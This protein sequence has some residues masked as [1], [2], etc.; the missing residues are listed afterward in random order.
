M[1]ANT[2]RHPKSPSCSIQSLESRRLMAVDL[3]VTSI[4]MIDG[5]HDNTSDPT[6]AAITVTNFGDQ[7]ILPGAIDLRLRFSTDDVF[8][9]E[10]DWNL[11]FVN[12]PSALGG[13]ESWTYTM[14]RRAAGQG[15]GSFRLI[16]FADGFDLITETNETNNIMVTD[17]GTVVYSNG[18]LESTDIYGTSFNDVITL[19]ADDENAYVTVN[20]N[21]HHK[22]I[23]DIAKHIFIDG[24]AGND[25]ITASPD[26]PV[27]LAIT[28]SGGKDLIVGGA[29]NDELSGA[30]GADRVIGGAGD[31]YCLGGAAGDRLYGEAG[32]DT[33][34]GAGGH[35]FVYGGEG[36]NYLL[37]G[38]GNDRLFAKGNAAND[39]LSGNAGVDLGEADAGDLLAGIETAV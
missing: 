36:S 27:R 21:T 37:G 38:I 31:D 3:A 39:T 30:T 17:P 14:S 22:K 35:D 19:T 33:L 2:S 8:N 26:F 7:A 4:Q 12:N 10:D 20:G 9:N 28:G 5:K 32:N 15:D 24:S 6:V 16:A 25:V 18:E 1:L 11:G 23:A 13:G 29:G 34:S